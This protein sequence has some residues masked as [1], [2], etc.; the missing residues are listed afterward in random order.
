MHVVT[1]R[2]RSMKSFTVS[3]GAV[4]FGAVV[5]STVVSGGVEARTP[6]TP[7]DAGATTENVS[8]ID[9]TMVAEKRFIPPS[10]HLA[11]PDPQSAP[12]TT[13]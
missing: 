1:S 4:S 9:M 3:T 7:S 8:A 11:Q 6:S 5:S 13:M 10:S 12:P 2:S